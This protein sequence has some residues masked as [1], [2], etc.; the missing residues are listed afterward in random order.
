LRRCFVGGLRRWAA[1]LC[2]VQ[3]NENVLI[4]MPA[5]LRKELPS[6]NLV[7]NNF[8]TLLSTDYR[9]TARSIAHF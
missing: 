9:H 3:P 1:A 2:L 7:F 4:S 8:D 6:H 5:A